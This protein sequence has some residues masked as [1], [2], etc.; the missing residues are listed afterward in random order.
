[1]S[2]REARTMTPT[3]SHDA[4]T[5][6]RIIEACPGNGTRYVLALT[7]ISGTGARALGASEGSVLVALWPGL[8]QSAAC[9]LR[10]GG[11]Y[12]AHYLAEKLHVNDADAAALSAILMAEIGGAS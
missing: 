9:V 11:F 3:R 8:R 1:M 2:A 5:T 4:I 10:P 12:A 6:T 7:P